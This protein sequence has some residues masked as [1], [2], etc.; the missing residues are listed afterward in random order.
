VTGT[1]SAT[2][3]AG[4]N[5][6]PT[7]QTP[8]GRISNV[9]CFDATYQNTLRQAGQAGAD[10]MLVPGNDWRLTDPIDT[11]VAVFRAIENGY[12][13]VRQASSGLSI[14][15][16]Y[17][18]NVLAATDYFTTNQQVMVAYVPTQGVRTIYAAIGDLFAWLS[19]LGLFALVG[20]VIMRRRQAARA[21]VG[22]AAPTSPP[23]VSPRE[24]APTSP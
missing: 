11:Q 6:V 8:Y 20:V 10:I 12:S 16:D 23:E 9:V 2:T 5:Q 1:E 17:E 24:A 15:A 4:V 3:V 18:G 19:L 7:V 13:L 22:L 14:A 21:E